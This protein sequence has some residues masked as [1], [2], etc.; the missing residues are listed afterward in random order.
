MNKNVL[1]VLAGGFVVAILVA[2][3][4]QASLGGKKS[5]DT[6]PKTQVLVAAKDLPIGKE[7]SEGDLK[8]QTWPG[9][10]AFQGAI[11]RKKPDEKASDALKG[12]LIQRVSAGQP[13][14]SNAIFKEGKANLVAATLDKGMRAMAIPVKANTMAGGF[15][16]PGVFVDVILSYKVSTKSRENPEVQSLVNKAASETILQNVRVLAVDQEAAREEE[17]AKVAK[18]VTLEVTPAGAEKLAVAAKLGDLVLSMR[19]IG[20]ENINKGDTAT[21]D[22]EAAKV[23]REVARL[24]GGEGAGSVVR[25]YSGA[26][27]ET[28]RPRQ[29]GNPAAAPAAQQASFDGVEDFDQ[30]ENALI[31]IDQLREILDR[32]E[33]VQGVTGNYLDRA[34]SLQGV[35]GEEDE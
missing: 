17:K 7:L 27:M 6:G 31:T 33:A 21:T 24:Q 34:E 8:W 19:G 32:V 26:K 28:V 35:T 16:S 4:V 1:I 13:V 15:V 29:S 5:A 9:E 2:V 18:T 11:I 12:R 3:L 20:D 22:L 14:L 30:E 25:V 10:K 23:M